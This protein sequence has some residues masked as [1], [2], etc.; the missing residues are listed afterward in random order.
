[1]LTLNKLLSN[2]CCVNDEIS[3]WEER[4]RLVQEKKKLNLL[5]LLPNLLEGI[6]DLEFTIAKFYRVYKVC[7]DAATHKNE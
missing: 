2:K 1:M 4:D 3:C 6:N 7:P 5:Y